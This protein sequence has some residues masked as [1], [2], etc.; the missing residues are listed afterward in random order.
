MLESG[1]VSSR[2]IAGLLFACLMLSACRSKAPEAAPAEPA[3]SDAATPAGDTTVAAPD[4]RPLIVAFGDSLTAGFGAD[5]GDSYPDYLEKDLNAMGY[6]Y[7]VINQGISG[8]TTK[9]GV[10]RLPDVLHLKPVVV[11]VAFGGNDGLR[12][13]PIASTR[14]N[15][16]RIVSTLLD[17]GAKV[18]LGGITL[19]PNYGPDYI[20]QFNQTYAL[21]AA[22]Y[23]VPMLPFL[24]KNVYGVPGGMQP[25]GIHATDQGNAQ[26]AK[27]L[28]PLI[29]PALKK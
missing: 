9:D 8:N 18:V 3:A 23:H 13:L 21:L 15:L 5:T 14:E 7:Q 11:I 25:D 24:L 19:P 17:G 29:V 28:L 12:G 16:D 2:Y 1:L 4:G 22:K 10:D 26:V 6:R 27:N 20:R